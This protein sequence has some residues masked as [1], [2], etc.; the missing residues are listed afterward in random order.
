MNGLTTYKSCTSGIVCFFRNNSSAIFK[1][2][3]IPRYRPYRKEK[4]PN[5]KDF[6]GI[7]TGNIRDFKFFSMSIL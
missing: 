6:H 7:F 1:N 5:I 4:H 3:T 2:Q